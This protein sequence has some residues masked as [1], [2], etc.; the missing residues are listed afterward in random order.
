MLLSDVYFCSGNCFGDY[1]L[2]I[3]YSRT[4]ASISHKGLEIHLWIFCILTQMKINTVSG[5][6]SGRYFRGQSWKQSKSDYIS[7]TRIQSI[8]GVALPKYKANWN[9]RPACMSMRMVCTGFGEH[10]SLSLTN[11]GKLQC[12]SLKSVVSIRR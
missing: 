3:I 12:L 1:P 4:E 9:I 5:V 2:S 10:M 6:L 8:V 7:L 11:R